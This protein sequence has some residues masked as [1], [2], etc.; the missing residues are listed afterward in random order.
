MKVGDMVKAAYVRGGHPGIY[1]TGVVV[2]ME[3]VTD[4]FSEKYAVLES[5]TYVRILTKGKIMTF[6]LEED[7]F[8]VI[9]ENR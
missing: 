8:E 1:H 5:N 9:S 4:L 7:K 3:E 6:D 2:E